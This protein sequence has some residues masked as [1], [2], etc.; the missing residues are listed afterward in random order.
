MSDRGE[1]EAYLAAE[2]DSLQQAHTAGDQAAV[3]RSI[4]HVRAEAGPETAA[5]LEQM[6][7]D[8]EAHHPPPTLPA[9]TST[10]PPGGVR[11]LPP[12]SRK[13]LIVFLAMVIAV[14]VLAVTVLVTVIILRPPATT[15]A[16]PPPQATGRPAEVTTPP[17]TSTAT[18]TTSVPLPVAPSGET[19][20]PAW[21]ETKQIT[22]PG[23]G[24][25]EYGADFDTPMVQRS[26]YS[27]DLSYYGGGLDFSSTLVGSGPATLPAP[28]ACSY[29]TRNQTVGRVRLIPG[30][31]AW[32]IVT[33]GGGLVWL[34]LLSGGG[35]TYDVMPTL[36]FELMRW[37][38]TS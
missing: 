26:L 2:L 33:P 17:P 1:T 19:W 30:K 3:T 22:M 23:E 5:V 12:R 35:H 15:T 4:E 9:V 21:P 28:E 38:K 10:P 6:L 16:P 36:T 18:T 8:Q 25:V 14:L 11:E 20:T 37:E 13:L 34:H 27:A 32:C 29:A 7:K 31:T 24:G